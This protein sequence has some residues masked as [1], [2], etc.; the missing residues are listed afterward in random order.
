MAPRPSRRRRARHSRGRYRGALYPRQLKE[1]RSMPDPSF[2]RRVRTYRSHHLDSMHW[3]RY[4]PRDGDVLISTSYKSG[5]T[6]MQ[7]IVSLLLFG[8]G[9]LPARLND[10]SPWVDA[11]PR[12]VERTMAQ[13]E[14]Q[15]H[16]RFLK[17]YLPLD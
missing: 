4:R 2:P 3:D 9:P 6:W 17:S 10:L 1:N 14:R 15:E 7:R 8:P 13:L 5:T 12:P 16:R 11:R